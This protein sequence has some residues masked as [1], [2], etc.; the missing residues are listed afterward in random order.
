MVKCR[1]C[2]AKLNTYEDLI[3]HIEKTHSDEIPKDFSTTQYEYAL[4]MGRTS[5]SCVVCKQETKWNEKTRKY[6]RFCGKPVCK[7][8]Y[9]Q[10]FRKNMI[11]AHGKIHLLNDPEQQKKMLANRSI[12]GKYKWSDGTEI[13]Y[14]GSYERDF[15]HFLDVFME[16]ESTDIM[17]PSPHVYYYTYKGEQ[18]FYIP[19]FFI[20]SLNLEI[21]IK[22]GGDNPNNHHKIQEVDKEKERLKDKVLLSQKAFSYVKITNKNYDP[23]FEF[24]HQLKKQYVADEQMPARERPIFIVREGAELYGSTV[25]TESATVHGSYDKVPVYILLTYT[26][27]PV[28]RMVRKYTGNPYS[29]ASIAFDHDLKELYSFGRKSK[30]EWPTFISENIMDGIY[31]DAGDIA[32]YGIYVTFVTKAELTSMRQRLEVF[33]DNAKKM[34]YSFVGLVNFAFGKETHRENEY[35]CSQFVAEILRSGRPELFNR[36]PSLYNPYQLSQLKEVY[37]IAEGK[38]TEYDGSIVDRQTKSILS[39]IQN[40]VAVGEHTSVREDFETIKCMNE[41]LDLI[42]AYS[43]EPELKSRNIDRKI[44]SVI[45]TIDPMG[46]TRLPLG[47]TQRNLNPVFAD[48]IASSM[49]H[50]DINIF[51]TK[52]E[53]IIR[54]ET[55]SFEFS[56]IYRDLNLGK[57]VL[58]QIASS[59][60]ELR[61]SCNYVIAWCEHDYPELEKSRLT[62]LT[63][64]KK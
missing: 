57:M 60:P 9:I 43:I 41:A 13:G 18:K 4:R 5:G 47:F 8:K 14:T 16:F 45:Q 24:L 34:R 31:K 30:W 23:F 7:E 26:N 50:D 12:S 63:G 61:A 27:T 36:D 19:D 42:H 58:K 46:Y 52:M 20:P 1:S 40:K 6:H 44:L 53:D 33:K 25:V 55:V 48:L 11:G 64:V 3:T 56:R 10:S 62:E 21:E 51:K 37:R 22:D 39:K 49:S 38:L 59:T 15:L 17:S 54:Q 32:T 28:A 35:F 29:H 2:G